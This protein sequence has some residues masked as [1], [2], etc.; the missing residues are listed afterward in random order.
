MFTGIIQ[1]IG[2][3]SRIES[4]DSDSHIIFKAE[5]NILDDMKI[6]DSISVN[7]ICL[8]VVGKT[9]DTFSVDVSN[10]TMR[11]TTFSVLKV[12]NNVNL[13]KAMV[14]SDRISGHFV[15][16]HIDGIGIVKEKK[17][18]GR[19][20]SFLIEFPADLKKFVSKKGSISI[21]GVSLTI[22]SIK[23]NNFDVNIIPHTLSETIMSEYKE[24]TKVNIEVD[25]I[26]RYLDKL[27]ENK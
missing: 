19:S 16:G 9:E 24:D 14:L 15:S 26:A 20:I 12:N 25:L 1:T 10:E 11:L 7:G 17:K 23:D 22:N 4:K 21:D 3:I 27:I 5:K 2:N 6:G 8:S 18:V 13:E